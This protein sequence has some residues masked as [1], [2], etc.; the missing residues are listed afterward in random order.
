MLWF[1]Y[2]DIIVKCKIILQKE[3]SAPVT[4]TVPYAYQT[5]L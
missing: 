2:N 5:N 4:L 1:I 3:E